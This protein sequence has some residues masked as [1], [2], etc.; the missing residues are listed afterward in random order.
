MVGC[1]KLARLSTGVVL[2]SFSTASLLK[3][4]QS[5]ISLGLKGAIPVAR[6][7]ETAFRTVT[8]LFHEVLNYFTKLRSVELACGG[9][10]N[11]NIAF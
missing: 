9:C 3:N 11:K 8:A 5:G 1:V 6:I 7:A 10:F 4:A 2:F